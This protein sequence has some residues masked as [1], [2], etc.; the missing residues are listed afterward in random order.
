MNVWFYGQKNNINISEIR[1]FGEVVEKKQELLEQLQVDYK[2][3]NETYCFYFSNT[4]ETDWIFLKDIKE[5]PKT[6]LEYIFPIAS[7]LSLLHNKGLIFYNLSPLNILCNT[8]TKAIK[9]LP[10]VIPLCHFCFLLSEYKA[11]ELPYLHDTRVD[12]YSLGV[13]FYEIITQELPEDDIQENLERF[14][15]KKYSSLILKCLAVDPSHR[16]SDLAELAYS[17]GEILENPEEIPGRK[18]ILKKWI[19]TEVVKKLKAFIESIADNSQKKSSFFMRVEQVGKTSLLRQACEFCEQKHIRNIVIK[20]NEASV[21]SL[22]YNLSKL[23]KGIIQEREYRDIALKDYFSIEEIYHKTK[24]RIQSSFLE[25]Q[26][27]IVIF[28]DDLHLA[29]NE[30]LDI[31]ENFMNS[32]ELQSKKIFLVGCSTCDQ[33]NTFDLFLEKQ[34]QNQGNFEIYD[35]GSYDS[36]D[37]ATFIA[38]AF[39][40]EKAPEKFAS[41][42]S[43]E[44]DNNIGYVREILNILMKKD[45][46]HRDDMDWCI[47]ANSIEEIAL[48]ET[49]SDSLNIHKSLF[50]EKTANIIKVLQLLVAPIHFETLAKIIQPNEESIEK[51]WKLSYDNIVFIDTDFSI[52]LSGNKTYEFDS[53]GDIPER[54]FLLLKSKKLTLY[55]KFLF[56]EASFTLGNSKYIMDYISEIFDYLVALG[57]EEYLEKYL[58]KCL[59]RINSKHLERLQNVAELSLFLKRYTIC[60]RFYKKMVTDYITPISFVGL[61]RLELITDEIS[62]AVQT[63][64]HLKSLITQK[65][66]LEYAWYYALRAKIKL[67]SGD[68]DDYKQSIERALKTIEKLIA[69]GKD[70]KPSFHLYYVIITEDIPEFGS[71]ALEKFTFA[72]RLAQSLAYS[73]VQMKLFYH[74]AYTN[75]IT[76]QYEDALE[77][78][79][80]AWSYLE[81][82][83]ILSLKQKLSLDLFRS[84]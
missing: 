47:E 11:P 44:T 64:K 28:I 35:L 63:L 74:I 46:L 29:G 57:F 55:E 20:C 8:K 53:Y 7:S 72:N 43:V 59:G 77:N 12:I 21:S 31:I 56:L 1:D 6:L 76:S 32:F 51:L 65:N 61:A 27:P 26:D 17:F 67:L 66:S 37:V 30:V 80:K 38:N 41:F 78:F 81:T 24:A 69:E 60:S 49:F 10:P 84:I 9:F 45:I 42:L 71:F 23:N 68:M 14:L 3:L 73:E 58:E 18:Y 70:V 79:Q 54:L 33:E 19:S 22:F 2:I 36:E 5:K 62:K 40:I 50:G 75:T 15:P 16:F 25:V 4:Q 83:Y 52:S 13:T 82:Y 39:G 34:S 48:P